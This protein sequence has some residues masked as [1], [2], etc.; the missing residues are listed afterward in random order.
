MIA[1]RHNLITY[2][3]ELFFILFFITINLVASRAR[4]NYDR[5][6][7]NLNIKAKA[8]IARTENLL[9]QMIPEKNFEK[10]EARIPFLD[11]L[12]QVSILYSD[13][14][15]FIAFSTDRHPQD[16]ARILSQLFTKFEKYTI[17]NKCYKVHTIGDCCVA[18]GLQ[19]VNK[20][21]SLEPKFDKTSFE[22]SE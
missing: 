1:S 9:K 3:D 18:L 22:N 2:L 10:L 21:M 6:S 14:C 4:E 7:Y 8:A 15:G 5:E 11:R 12:Q 20:L 17:E 19:D 13:I 16:I